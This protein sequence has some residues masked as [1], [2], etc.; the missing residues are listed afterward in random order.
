MNYI[1]REKLLEAMLLNEMALNRMDAMEVCMY[2]SRAFVKHFIYLYCAYVKNSY[3]DFINHW[4]NELKG[5][6]KN[7]LNIVLK[8]NKKKLT[9]EQVDDW[10]L[11]VLDFKSIIND[12]DIEHKPMLE[13]IDFNKAEEE[14]TRFVAY[15]NRKL[16]NNNRDEKDIV[17]N[18]NWKEIKQ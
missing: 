13:G 7:I 6:L 10:F 1:S 17:N 18:Y 12:I 14:Y 3:L 8:S 16:L 11:T 15:I 2:N 9:P 4:K 5:I